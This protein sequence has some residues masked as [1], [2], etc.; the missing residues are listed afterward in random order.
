MST[1]PTKYQP[2]P[3]KYEQKQWLYEQY[4]GQLLSQNEIA[5]ET[6]VSRKKIRMEMD[7]HGIPSRATGC[8]HDQANPFAGFY[9]PTE[10]PPAP[11]NTQQDHRTEKQ[12]L[13]EKQSHERPEL[14][15]EPVQPKHDDKDWLYEQYW[16]ELKSQREMAKEVECSQKTLANRMDEFG[17]P[18][19]GTKSDPLA[20]FR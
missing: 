7:K 2:T 12:E 16:G 19:R 10:T 20:G 17:I 9:N 13:R 5:D 3:E 1:V 4:W 15:E 11:E 14:S 18:T 8:N 6:P